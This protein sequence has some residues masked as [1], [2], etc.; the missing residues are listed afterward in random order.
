MIGIKQR[1]MRYAKE[2]GRLPV[3]LPNLPETKEFDVVVI[4][5]SAKLSNE[6]RG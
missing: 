1:I 4:S 3:D 5:K 6:N 2:H